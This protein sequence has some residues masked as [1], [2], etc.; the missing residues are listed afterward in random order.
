MIRCV[1]PAE[2]R[3]KVQRENG[4]CSYRVNSIT[5]HGQASA[6]ADHLGRSCSTVGRMVVEERRRDDRRRMV[7]DAGSEAERHARASVMAATRGVPCA[8]ARVAIWRGARVAS[9]PVGSCQPLN[10][11]TEVGRGEELPCAEGQ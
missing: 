10:L 11:G 3:R 7:A 4:A 1:S 9:L 5:E 2:V 8:P 6:Q